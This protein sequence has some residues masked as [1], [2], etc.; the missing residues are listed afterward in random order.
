MAIDRET[1]RRLA[2][3]RSGEDGLI[4]SAFLST[5]P[6]DNWRDRLSTF[7]NSARTEYEK[8]NEL[9]KEQRRSLD[10]DFGR[11]LD[12]LRYERSGDTM[13]SL[14]VFADG[15][16]ELFEEFE[17]PIHFTD[18]VRIDRV[19]YLRPM[20]CA[21]STLEPFVMARVS[22]D[23]STLLMVDAGRPIRE[24][25]F[26]GPYLKSSDRETGDLSI[27]EYFAAARQETLIEQHHKEVAAALD[28]LL[29]DSGVRRV[30]LCGQHDIVTNFRKSLSQATAERVLG[31][32]AW[33]AAASTKKLVA[34]A[35]DVV[36]EGLRKEQES[37]AKRVQEGLGQGGLGVSGF[38]DTIA[39]L[40]RGQVHVLLVA[41]DYRPAGWRCFE[42]DYAG[43][44][45]VAAC[46]VCGGGTTPVDDAAGEAMR[47]AVLGGAWVEVTDQSFTLAEMG[48]FAA[49]LRYS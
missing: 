14:A 46:P 3:A 36:R 33:D 45:Q 20:L 41:N 44:G 49:L 32:F 4:V 47:M 13:S 5:T 12:I 31:E 26:A 25:E 9:S 35:R 34:Q 7:L 30:V 8:E 16:A 18:R 22:R 28:R 29:T 48:G 21:F 1:L 42:C 15:G 11:I 38:D 39:A 37:L 24:D 17:L 27:K 2:A 23:D 40:H 43:L 6:V 10:R 19:A